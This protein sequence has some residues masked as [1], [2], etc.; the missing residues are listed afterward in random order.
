MIFVYE[1]LLFV[2]AGF[3]GY[4]WSEARETHS[5]G[6]WVVFF[7]NAMATVGFFFAMAQEAAKLS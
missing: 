4:M 5:T 2:F 3:T 7:L 1:A 6:A